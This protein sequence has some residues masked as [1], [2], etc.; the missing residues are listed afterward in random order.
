[1]RDPFETYR[2]FQTLDKRSREYDRALD[3]VLIAMDE[4][5]DESIDQTEEERYTL[6]RLG[7]LLRAQAD[8]VEQ[9]R[10]YR[11]EWRLAQA[12]SRTNQG[13]SSVTTA[14][15]LREYRARHKTIV[16]PL[17]DDL[18][19]RFVY[20]QIR[21]RKILLKAAVE[22]NRAFTKQ[23]YYIDD[24]S[25]LDAYHVCKWYGWTPEAVTRNGLVICAVDERGYTTVGVGGSL[26]KW[27]HPK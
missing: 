20:R 14:R 5:P 3:V 7:D 8:A 12:L 4:C 15:G 27:K 19:G 22:A 18:M 2:E 6:Q 25:L 26:K 9:S 16:D 23:Y 21:A 24:M 10:K 17:T 1:M 13:W 11:R